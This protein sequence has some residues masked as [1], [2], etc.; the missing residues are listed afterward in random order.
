MNIKLERK[1]FLFVLTFIISMLVIFGLL[2]HYTNTKID[3]LTENKIDTNKV[4]IDNVKNV[5]ESVN[6]LNKQIDFVLPRIHKH[7]LNNNI[8][9]KNNK[10]EIFYFENYGYKYLIFKRD[11]VFQRTYSGFSNEI[12]NLDIE[13]KFLQFIK[14]D[15]INNNLEMG[16]IV[17]RVVVVNGEVYIYSMKYLFTREGKIDGGVVVLVRLKLF[18]DIENIISYRKI[19]ILELN[20]DIFSKNNDLNYNNI[21]N[22]LLSIKIKANDILETKNI[23]FT[24]KYNKYLDLYVISYIEKNV[25]IEKNDLLNSIYLPI[26]YMI[27][28]LIG[29]M[30]IYYKW[31]INKVNCSI[32]IGECINQ[33]KII[34]S[35]KII[36]EE[37]NGYYFNLYNNM[38]NEINKY[39]TRENILKIKDNLFELKKI[40]ENIDIKLNGMKEITSVYKNLEMNG[41]ML[42][43]NMAI[44]CNQLED[45]RLNNIMFMIKKLNQKLRDNNFNAHKKMSNILEYNNLLLI[46]EKIYNSLELLNTAD[47]NRINII[48]SFKR[49][50]E[51]KAN[52]IK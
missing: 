36:S 12:V 13:D 50:L 38:Q 4:L 8:D 46:L 18:V 47:K 6:L 10:D 14:K 44:L 52:E 43:I 23:K 45:S 9:T 39:E 25:N 22:K 16:Q 24:Y 2:V 11:S 40:T 35:H 19:Y 27:I 26:F 49:R 51:R 20:N 5:F 34:A 17:N 15:S 21:R 42:E 1:L 29:L 33:S 7:L 30:L 37:I 48:N 31:L 32:K 41:N 28:I 3:S